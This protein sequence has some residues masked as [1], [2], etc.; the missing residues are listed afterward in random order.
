MGRNRIHELNREHLAAP[1]AEALAGLRLGLWKRMRS[2]LSSWNPK[3]VYGCVFG[4]AARGDGGTQ[5]DVDV[6][7]VRAPVAAES[8]PRRDSGIVA[9]AVAGHAPG[10]SCPRSSQHGRRPRPQ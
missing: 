9:A 8:D 5:S 1:V 6:L 3:P 7:L 2:T 4:S 10:N